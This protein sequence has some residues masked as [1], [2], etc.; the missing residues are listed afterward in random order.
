MRLQTTRADAMYTDTHLT[1]TAYRKVTTANANA[2]YADKTHIS[3]LSFRPHVLLL[4]RT[5]HKAYKVAIPISNSCLC[6]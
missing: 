3:K 2:T 4:K 1:V 5:P 6:H